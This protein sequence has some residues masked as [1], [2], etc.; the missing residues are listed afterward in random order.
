MF[1]YENPP[2]LG[3]F[4]I[5]RYSLMTRL[6]LLSEVPDILSLRERRYGKMTF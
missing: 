1:L 3:D 5:E 4:R 2:T 6:P